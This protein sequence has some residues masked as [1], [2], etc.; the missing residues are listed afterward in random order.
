MLL[1]DQSSRPAQRHPVTQREDSAPDYERLITG[2]AASAT[3]TGDYGSES[4]AGKWLG[5]V[6]RDQR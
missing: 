5:G 4:W 2:R 6:I 3:I 1:Q